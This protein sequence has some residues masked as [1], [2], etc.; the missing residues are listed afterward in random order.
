MDDNN[1]NFKMLSFVKLFKNKYNDLI[2]K[3]A[4]ECGISKQEADILL[5]L[6]NNSNLNRAVDIVLYRGFSKAYVSKAINALKN[7]NLITVCN[8]INDKRYQ[9]IEI[10]E[11][12]YD[13]LNYLKNVQCD[14]FSCLS[15]GISQEE[16]LVY[17][18]IVDKITYNILNNMKG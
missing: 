13:I 5:F 14:F 7:K 17:I 18:N 11:N 15:E 1:M 4:K 8:D 12:A 16:F 6:G 3:K 2:E 9:Y 10:N